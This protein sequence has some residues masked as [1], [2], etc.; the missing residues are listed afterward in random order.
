MNSETEKHW[1]IE[2]RELTDSS[3]NG[4]LVKLEVVIERIM[5]CLIQKRPYVDSLNFLLGSNR[6]IAVISPL[7]PA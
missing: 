4:T 2:E 6:S 3:P 5:A 7:T 1:Q